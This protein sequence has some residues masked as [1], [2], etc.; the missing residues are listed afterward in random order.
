MVVEGHKKNRRCI[1][2]Y[3]VKRGQTIIISILQEK[4][5]GGSEVQM[6]NA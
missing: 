2:P 4:R 5:E 3:F 6:T 1:T